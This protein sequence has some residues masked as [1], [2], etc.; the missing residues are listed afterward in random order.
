LRNAKKGAI[1]KIISNI[2]TPAEVKKKYPLTS[3]ARQIKTSRDA[4]LTDIITSASQKF[5]LI[6]GPC[7]ADN[8]DALNT[9]TA[10]LSAIQKTTSDK[11][12]ILPRVYTQKPR[13]FAQGYMGIFHHPNPTAPPN[14]VEGIF[15]LRHIHHLILENHGLTTADELLYPDLYPYIDDLVSYFAIGARSVENQLHR[16]VASGIDAPVGMKNPISG[17]MAAMF[18]SIT[19]ATRAHRFMYRGQE[20]QTSGNPM[21]HAILRGYRDHGENHPNYHIENLLDASRRYEQSNLPHPCIIVDVSHSNS[22]KNYLSQ[23]A[24]A[25]EIIASR[26]ACE[27]LGAIKG[28]MLESYLRDGQQAPG[29]SIFGKSLTDPCLGWGK[30][31]EFINKLHEAL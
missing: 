9:Y 10:R 4:D 21:T 6:I 20:V 13:T 28:L 24:A 15:A 25:M 22:D 18:N 11:I 27:A 1:M 7:S 14:L 17:S 12:L 8:P 30:T 31:E 2:P 3:A 5:L 19:A 26:K 16:F 23:P 29:G